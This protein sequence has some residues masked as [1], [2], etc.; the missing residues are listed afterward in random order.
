MKIGVGMKKKLQIEKKYWGEGDIPIN[1]GEN[2]F[3]I[4]PDM[5]DH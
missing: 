3:D 2:D 4:D 1:Y 5:G